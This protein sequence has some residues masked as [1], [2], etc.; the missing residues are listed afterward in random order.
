MSVN[1]AIDVPP[2]L[3]VC[4]CSDSWI[5]E[6]L[7]YPEVDP[8]REGSCTSQMQG[9]MRQRAKECTA[10]ALGDNRDERAAHTA[11]AARRRTADTTWQH[12]TES[13]IG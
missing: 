11:L 10:A 3:G 2:T 7:S 12:A 8:A 13:K 1:V 5:H 4:H 9:A 6:L